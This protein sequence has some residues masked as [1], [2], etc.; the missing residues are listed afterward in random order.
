VERKLREVEN[1]LKNDNKYE[2][3]FSNMID[4]NYKLKEIETLGEGGNGL[5]LKCFDKTRW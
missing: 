3:N 1:K 4:R 5:V 2:G